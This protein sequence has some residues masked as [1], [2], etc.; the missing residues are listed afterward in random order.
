MKICDQCGCQ[1]SGFWFTMSD[2]T[3]CSANCIL[4]DFE[5][6]VTTENKELFIIF[7]LVMKFQQAQINHELQNEF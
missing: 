6:P 4:Q 2:A 7:Y 3:F 5:Q 1:E